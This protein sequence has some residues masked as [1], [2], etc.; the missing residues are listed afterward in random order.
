MLCFLLC[1]INYNVSGLGV[2]TVL[3]LNGEISSVYIRYFKHCTMH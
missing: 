1:V 3:Y 2:E